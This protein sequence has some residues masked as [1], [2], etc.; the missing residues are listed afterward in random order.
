[1]VRKALGPPVRGPQLD[2]IMYADIWQDLWSGPGKAQKALALQQTVKVAAHQLDKYKGP[3]AAELELGYPAYQAALGNDKADEAAKQAARRGHP[4]WSKVERSTQ[5]RDIE[6]A[7][8]TLEVAMKGLQRWPRVGQLERSKPD[9]AQAQARM[10]TKQRR[11]Q[12]RWAQQQQAQVRQRA[13]RATHD[14]ATWKTTSRCTRCLAL[15]STQAVAECSGVHPLHEIARKAREGGHQV[16]VAAF[17]NPATPGLHQAMV[18]CRGCGSTTFG[19]QQAI[20]H[21]L[22]RPCAPPTTAGQRAWHRVSVLGKHPKP[23]GCYKGFAVIG[24]APWPVAESQEEEQEEEETNHDSAAQQLGAPGAAS[25]S[26][27]IP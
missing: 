1:M 6:D 3:A 20:R 23:D 17:E 18:I 16:W 13:N 7:R 21:K 25:S 24:L 27:V 22:G 12:L 26:T 4:G 15:A 2:K 10:A 19:S 11:Q 14:W 8:I 9:E 5:I